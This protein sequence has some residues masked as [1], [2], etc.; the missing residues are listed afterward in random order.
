MNL[1]NMI[2]GALRFVGV[3][4]LHFGGGGG[5]DGGAA[6][7]QQQEAE[8]QARIKAATDTINAIFNNQVQQQ[9]T[10]YKKQSGGLF[11]RGDPQ[12]MDAAEFAKKQQDYAK[13][14]QK[15]GGG[16]DY[17]RWGQSDS[18][19]GRNFLG[20]GGRPFDG[21]MSGVKMYGY[22]DGSG[23]GLNYANLTPEE[24]ALVTSFDPSGWQAESYTYFAPGDPRNSRDALYADTRSA[25]YDLNKMEV[26]RQA[27]EA[28]RVNRF[29]LARSGLLGG[30]VNV[31][32]VADIN[33]RTNEGLLRAG[34]IADQTAADLKA[35]DERTRANL[36][37]MAQSG[38]DTGSAATMALQG[39]N[40][41]AQ[42]VASAKA[43]ATIGGL[44]NDMSQAYLANQMNMGRS[45]GAQQPGQQWYG[46]SSPSQTYGGR[47]G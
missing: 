2:L 5:G 31:D 16:Q 37:S 9:G 4:G 20:S 15:A 25:V 38:I 39:L 10:R 30:S 6:A 27:K 46:V 8:R 3:F 7:A 43:G 19:S 36:I 26:D 41:N 33:R 42:S 14:L 44:F 45:A 40:S 1:M 47:T 12:Y 11:G 24:I 13:A 21:T 18:L 28:E 23:G 35:A 22:D 32:S 29:G 34:G 17:G